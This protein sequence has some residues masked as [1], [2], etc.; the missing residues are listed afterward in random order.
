MILLAVAVA[1]IALMPVCPAAGQGPI[2]TDRPDS[3]SVVPKGSTQFETLFEYSRERRGEGHSW[4][5]PN[6]LVRHGIT[7]R[8]ELRLE[9]PG[10]AW[11]QGGGAE[12]GDVSVGAKVQL[13][14]PDAAVPRALT[15]FATLPSG[16]PRESQGRSDYGAWLALE[17]SAGS[18][19][20][21]A[22]AGASRLYRDGSR[23]WNGI[24]WLSVGGDLRENV[25][26]YGELY[27]DLPEGS[28]W[29]PLMTWGLSIAQGARTQWDIYAGRGLDGRGPAGFAGVGYSV[30]FD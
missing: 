17:G 16:S 20:L 27:A 7:D 21:L 6:L 25:A 24:L 8:T 1:T 22:N 15:V 28:R 30:R 10:W 26:W 4:L 29:E 14:E 18:L 19:S 23:V 5:A 9:A 11:M 3:A 13:G 12:T 2:V